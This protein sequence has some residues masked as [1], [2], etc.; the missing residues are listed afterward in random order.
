MFKGQE[1]MR[2]AHTVQ[3]RLNYYVIKFQFNN[4]QDAPIK[5]E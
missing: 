4:N 5:V 2:Q 1:C 3:D